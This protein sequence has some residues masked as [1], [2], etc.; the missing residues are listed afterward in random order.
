[1]LVD[2]S[3]RETVL[4][5]YELLFTRSTSNKRLV[6]RSWR[7]RL[8]WSMAEESMVRRC[9]SQAIVVWRSG[10]TISSSQRGSWV[11]CKG[12]FIMGARKWIPSDQ[13]LKVWGVLQCATHKEKGEKSN[14]HFAFLENVRQPFGES[15]QNYQIAPRQSILSVVPFKLNHQH[16][17]NLFDTI[18]EI[19]F[20][21]IAQSKR[22]L[23][24]LKCQ[25]SLPR[26]RLTGRLARRQSGRETILLLKIN[27]KAN[28]KRSTQQKKFA[29]IA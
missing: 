21:Q 1:M 4:L 17:G 22:Y 28:W 29:K 24:L 5:F 25:K 11:S 16:K 14:L 18:S 23:K 7:R 9:W 26:S 3:C 2:V 12:R 6:E 19:G 8:R 20:L 15:S 13:I 27:L 10:R